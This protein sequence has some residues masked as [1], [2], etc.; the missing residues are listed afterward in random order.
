MS[1]L[2]V[3]CV[4]LILAGVIAGAGGAIYLTRPLTATRPVGE[5]RVAVVVTP[6]TVRTVSWFQAHQLEMTQKL[7]ACKDNPGGGMLDPE[8]QNALD[9]KEHVDT[10]NFLASAPK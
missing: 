7:G 5:A 10:Q 4:P 3:A 9:A 6:R 8:C 2:Q 1:P